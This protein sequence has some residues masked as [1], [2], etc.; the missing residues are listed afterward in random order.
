[1]QR[2]TKC[3]EISSLSNE[4]LSMY[5]TL[6]EVS[7]LLQ[8]EDFLSY[9]ELCFIYLNSINKR[10][11]IPLSNYILIRGVGFGGVEGIF[12]VHQVLA[13]NLLKLYD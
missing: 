8:V 9:R 3:S 1:M 2:T 11:S 12:T 10:I 7:Y 13:K 4:F 5:L 6:K